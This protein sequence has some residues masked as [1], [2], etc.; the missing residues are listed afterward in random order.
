MH[1]VVPLI[2]TLYFLGDNKS[3]SHIAQTAAAGHDFVVASIVIHQF[4]RLLIER[5]GMYHNADGRTSVLPSVCRN[6]LV[7]C[8]QSR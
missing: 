5:C 7:S 2:V 3:F 4:R 1:A 6:Q 8:S